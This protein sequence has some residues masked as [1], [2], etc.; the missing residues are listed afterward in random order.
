MYV[1]RYDITCYLGRSHRSHH[2][3]TMS[4]TIPCMCPIAGVFAVAHILCIFIY[5]VCMSMHIYIYIY[6][7]NAYIDMYVSIYIYICV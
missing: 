4:E 1:H 7:Y 3:C 5:H 2:A 6:M